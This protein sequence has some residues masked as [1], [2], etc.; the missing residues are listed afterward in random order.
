M[1]FAENLRK[2]R[3]K[4]GYTA[5]DFSALLDVK[6]STYAAY[7]NQGSEPKYETLCKIAS[8]LRVSTDE[9][10]GY[11]G[12]D[13]YDRMNK[14]I[15]S[16]GFEITHDKNGGL[17]LWDEPEEDE[18]GKKAYPSWEIDSP[19]HLYKIFSKAQRAFNMRTMD[20]FKSTLKEKIYDD[21]ERKEQIKRFEE[22]LKTNPK[23]LSILDAIEYTAA[24]KEVE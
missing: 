23:E 14:V 16:L 22:R 6:Y 9:L 11:E 3:E 1:S 4:A 10:I 24:K 7:E 21:Q 5:K 18:D 13:K 15:E 8:A 20:I 17:T 12:I 19:E 2:Y